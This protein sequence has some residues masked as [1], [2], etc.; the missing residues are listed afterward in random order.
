MRKPVGSMW[1]SRRSSSQ[2]PQGGRGRGVEGLDLSDRRHRPRGRG[3]TAEQESILELQSLA[4]N[5]AVA[6][7]LADGMGS[8]RIT[9]VDTIELTR[10]GMPPENGVLQI[11]EKT[12][13]KLTLALTQRGI[14]DEP[15]IMRVRQPEKVAGGYVARTHKVGSIEEPIVHEWWPKQ[16]RHKLSEGNYLDVDPD[17]E[18][19]LAEGEDEH[20]RDAKLAWEL[21]WKTVQDTINAFADGAGPPEATP[22]AATKALWRRYVK[23]LPK[24]LQPVGDMP[25][26]A[27]QRDVL[28]VRPGTF[29][30]WMWEITVARDGRM[31]HETKTVPARN[32]K[33]APKGAVVSEIKGYPQFQVPGPRSADFLDEIRAKWAPGKIIQGSKL[34]ASE[35]GSD[36]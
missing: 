21:T 15:P 19:K 9:T 11:R 35:S 31:Y 18:D 2:L 4:G 24:E 20:G 32:P 16:G 12:S 10:E 5:A 36:R 29:F 26:D 7:A 17:W 25:N 13:N 27:K 23:A 6:R 1:A 8:G 14:R 3:L 30:A 33:R 28:A 22:D 34:R